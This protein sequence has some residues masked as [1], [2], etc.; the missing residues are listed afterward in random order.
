MS[1]TIPEAES[2]RSIILTYAGWTA[3]S[4][5]SLR[6]TDQIESDHLSFARKSQ[7]RLC[8]RDRGNCDFS[9]RICRLASEATLRMRE[10]TPAMVVGWA[11]KL[12]NVY[13]KTASYVGDLGRPGL[14][15]VLHPPIDRGLWDGLK[16]WIKRYD[17]P[18]DRELLKRSHL[19]RRIKE[20]TEYETYATIIQGCREVAEKVPCRLI[21]VEQFW[22]GASA[23]VKGRRPRS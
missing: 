16:R 9:R 4:A 20:I 6:L 17:G 21:E 5:A 10:E 1:L 2:R 13:L 8:A 14:R 7:F 15:E 19:V 18:L 11:A 12:I 23:P 22:E 3:L